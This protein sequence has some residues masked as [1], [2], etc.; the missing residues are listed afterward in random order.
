AIADAV[1]APPA[2]VVRAVAV[3]TDAIE[4]TCVVEAFID[5]P[6]DSAEPWRTVDANALDRPVT[7][8]PRGSTIAGVRA[9]DGTPVDF[10]IL[11][12]RDAVQHEMSRYE[13]PWALNVR[14]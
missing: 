4:R 8:W 2:S 14:R 10:Q 1:P 13:T 3:N 12:E 5:L 9:A 11:D 6:I 7:F